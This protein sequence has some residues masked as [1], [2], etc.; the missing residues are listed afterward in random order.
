MSRR[1]HKSP[2]YLVVMAI[3]GLVAYL[4]FRGLMR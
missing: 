1:W 2:A 4:L 3:V